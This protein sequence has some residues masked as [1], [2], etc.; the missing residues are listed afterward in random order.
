M[1]LQF[2]LLLS[3]NMFHQCKLTSVYLWYTYHIIHSF[4]YLKVN[5]SRALL[6]SMKSTTYFC[7]S[8]TVNKI[9]EWTDVWLLLF[10]LNLTFRLGQSW[11]IQYKTQIRT[12]AAMEKKDG[13]S[14]YSWNKTWLCNPMCKSIQDFITGVQI[15]I[16]PVDTCK[17]EKINQYTSTSCLEIR[18]EGHFTF[19]LPRR[20]HRL[21]LKFLI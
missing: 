9:L 12:D 21:Y 7:S 13:R 15:G 10:V 11:R 4:V 14:S 17:E 5:W 20:S 19:G 1:G 16:Y 6:N 2:L 3:L 18:M 8:S